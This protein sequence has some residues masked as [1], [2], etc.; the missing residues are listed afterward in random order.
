MVGDAGA[1]CERGR[2]RTA[3]AAGRRVAGIGA[4]IWRARFT[5]HVAHRQTDACRFGGTGG[6]IAAAHH[7][8]TQR[9]R[10]RAGN[11]SRW[12]PL[13]NRSR[14]TV[15]TRTA[16]AG[17]LSEVAR[18]AKVARHTMT[19]DKFVSANGLRLHYL[20]Y[21]GAGDLPWVVC[22]HGL[23]GNAH[24]FDALAPHLAAGYHVISID[25]R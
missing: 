16:A 22:V 1:L 21:G 3:R 6:R 11:H 18:H 12:P 8:A 13:D 5:R 9:F 20:D 19:S 14:E 23:T 17:G 2:T 7:R 4:Q 25:V 24:N 10:T 15:W